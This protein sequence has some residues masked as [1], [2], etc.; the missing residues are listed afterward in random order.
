ML[1]FAIQEEDCLPEEEAD[2][3]AGKFIDK[4]AYNLL[5][6]SQDATVMK[7]DGSLLLKFRKNVL[8]KHLCDTAYDALLPAAKATNNRGTAAGHRIIYKKDDGS[9]SNSTRSVEVWSG[10]AGYFDRYPRI[11]YCRQTAYTSA[12]F[13][14]F[15][16]SYPFVEAVSELFR[17][18]VPSRWRAQDA[19]IQK[20]NQD[21]RIANSCFTTITV[22]KNW[23]TAVHKD[24]GDLAEG[25]G[26]LT[27]LEKGSFDGGYL[28]LPRFKVAVRLRQGDILFYDVHEWH[29]NTP[30]VTSDFDFVRLGLVFYYRKKM[31]EC[32]SSAEELDRAKRLGGPVINEE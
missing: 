5:L 13:D 21:F 28:V 24:A 31:L 4:S 12:N 11:P 8:P 26:V 29:G 2:K 10:L 30:F 7:P 27:V 32:G 17:T 19:Y 22:N 6:S 23:Q 14:Q 1:A 16:T 3:L 15:A 9:M 18:H 25:F 20:T